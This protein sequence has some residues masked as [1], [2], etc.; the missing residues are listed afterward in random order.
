MKKPID[1][2]IF[3]LDGTLSDSIP[4]AI[5]SI[6]DMIA[7]LGYPKKS[8]EE[9]KEHIG[10]GERA[11]VSGSI[12]TEDGEKVKAAQKIYYKHVSSRLGEVTLFSHVKELLE[13]FKSKTK[14][15]I[16]NKR[17]EFIIKIL[18]NQDLTRYFKEVL[19][20]DGAPC[21]KPDPCALL[22]IIE[23]YKIPNDRVLFIGDMTIDVETGK[24]AG[25][26][27]C[28]VTYG[29]DDKEKLKKSSPDFLIDDLLELKDL[30][31]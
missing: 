12:G 9:I 5:E 17:D 8:K 27:T 16:S 3:D 13:L 4:S 1:L 26:K 30:I 2:L 10:F 21:L 29:F 22:K 11:L 7:E 20:G 28:A 15:I 24:N 6:Q 19:G 14:I 18:A 25:A 23:K 31:E